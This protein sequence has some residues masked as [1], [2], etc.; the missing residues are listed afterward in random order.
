MN[1]NNNKI[2]SKSE[3]AEIVGQN[4]Q[5]FWREVHCNEELMRELQTAHYNKKSRIITP[6]Q[7]AIIRV[8]FC[9]IDNEEV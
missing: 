8:H 9:V 4:R 1:S 5:S 3:F 2:M 6:R 7:Q